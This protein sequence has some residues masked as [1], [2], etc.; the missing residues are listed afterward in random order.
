M[1][2]K[3]P[4]GKGKHIPRSK[5]KGVRAAAANPQVKAVASSPDVPVTP[6]AQTRPVATPARKTVSALSY[7][8]LSGD[9]KRIGILA[10]I[11][12]VI[13]L[14]LYFVLV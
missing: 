6:E 13:L 5:R 9:I 12:L 14:I 3:R 8:Y 10:A 2:A 7:P 4:H 1:P 11:M